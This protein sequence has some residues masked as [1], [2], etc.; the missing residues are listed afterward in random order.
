MEV[1]PSYKLLVCLHCLHNA[2]AVE[3]ALHCLDSSTYSY[4]YC[5]GGL[6][7]YWNGLMWEWVI[8]WVTG[9]PIHCFD[10]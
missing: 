10:Y 9:H 6:E 5:K 2:Y 3:T 8:G 7:R 1:A 4:I